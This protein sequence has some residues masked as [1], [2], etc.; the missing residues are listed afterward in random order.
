MPQSK[1]EKFAKLLNRYKRYDPKKEGYGSEASWREAWDVR[2]GHKE[3]V[4]TLGENDPLKIMGFS[5]MPTI[6]EL[7]TAYRKAMMTYHPD[8]GGTE[9]QCKKI[10][11]AYSVLLE[12]LE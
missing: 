2:M 6:A 4:E 11:A 12:K 1:S 9:E 5:V 3:A 10:M 7:K 8:K